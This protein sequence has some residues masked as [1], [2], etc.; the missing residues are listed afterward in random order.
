MLQRIFPSLF[1]H[2][3][4]IFYVCNILSISFV[5][6]ILLLCLEVPLFPQVNRNGHLYFLLVFFWPYVLHLN[7]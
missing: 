4:I 7:L 1:C 5:V 2:V 6:L 3:K